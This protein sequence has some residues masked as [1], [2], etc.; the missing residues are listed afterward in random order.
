[1]KNLDFKT[2]LNI[3]ISIALVALISGVAYWA[4]LPS[5]DYKAQVIDSDNFVISIQD[6]AYDPDLVKVK[7]G[8]TVSWLNDETEAG[9]QH[10]VTSYD[11][12]DDAATG[13]L[14]DSD[15]LSLSDTFTYTFDTEGVYYYQCSLHPFMVG[16][17]CVGE[18]SASLDDDCADLVAVSSKEEA[19]A[20]EE[21]DFS[22]EEKAPG[23]EEDILSNDVL[24][25]GL[26]NKV[27]EAA[28]PVEP[29]TAVN[30][31]GD[32]EG[33]LEVDLLFPAADESL[34]SQSGDGVAESMPVAEAASDEMPE[35]GPAD[36]IYIFALMVAL[37]IGYRKSNFNFQVR[38]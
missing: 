7:L 3:V 24:G 10:T 32:A 31:E 27:D 16:K 17:V 28:P 26:E 33:T 11:P 30:A 18:A 8:T 35:S 21:K 9:I 13:V 38:K 25:A 14:F 20:D 5:K 6:F 23:V 19:P 36:F 15:L 2:K 29:D 34:S 1:M 12:E 22:S 37:Y 4:Q